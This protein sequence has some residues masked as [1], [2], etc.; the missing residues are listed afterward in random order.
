M[1]LKPF[2]SC[3][4]PDAK[5]HYDPENI[6]QEGGFQKVTKEKKEVSEHFT[7]D[8]AIAYFQSVSLWNLVSEDKKDQAR[9]ALAEHCKRRLINGFMERPLDVTGI[10]GIK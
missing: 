10:V 5:R 3:E 9:K 7:L 6:L 2:I 8:H 4:I 1:I